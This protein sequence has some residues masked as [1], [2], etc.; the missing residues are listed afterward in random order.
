MRVLIVEDEAVTMA[1][2]CKILRECSL[3]KK[4]HIA[5]TGPQMIEE[6]RRTPPDLIF[7]DIVI[8]GFDG[9]TSLAE[10]RR[11]C[12]DCPC[13]VI[14]AHEDFSFAQ[15]AIRLGVI[16][17]L[18]KPVSKKTL[19]LTLE[20]ATSHLKTRSDKESGEIGDETPLL[21]PTG[22]APEEGPIATACAYLNEHHIEYGLSLEEVASLVGL[23][24]SH[25]CRVFKE[26]TGENFTEYLTRL[27]L[28]AAARLLLNTRASIGQIALAVGY[29]DP[30]YFSRIFHRL[31]GVTPKEYR[32]LAAKNASRP[33]KLSRGSFNSAD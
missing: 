3:V 14:S 4:I 5:R 23:S 24:P 33:A 32:D 1:S 29:A 7:L 27:R 12:P 2:I 15:R 19:L 17:Y 30:N 22:P 18:L 26:Q 8:P 6:C 13:I 10:V 21:P 25:F 9:L 31:T 16:D 20:R 28:N 11:F